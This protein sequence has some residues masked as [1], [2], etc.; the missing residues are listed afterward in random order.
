MMPRF[1]VTGSGVDL[2]ENAVGLVKP[3]MKNL[4]ILF[5]KLSAKLIHLPLNRSFCK[6]WDQRTLMLS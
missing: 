5:R 3:R 6:T 2:D 4:T 1:Q